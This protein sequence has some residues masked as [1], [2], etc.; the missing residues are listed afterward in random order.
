MLIAGIAV[1]VVVLGTGAWAVFFR[2]S[3]SAAAGVTYRATA[4]T[5]GTL[6]QTVSASG[7]VDATDTE[8]LAFPAS[9][10][11][12]GVWVAAGQKVTKGQR[13]AAIDSAQ[14]SSALAAARATLATAKAKL[15]S[16][17]GAS[18]TQVSA[19]NA[20]ITVAQNQVT[21]AT[22]DLDGATLTAPFAGTV[23]TVGYTVGQQV[24]SGSSSGTGSSSPSE[25]GS[26]T[27]SQGGGGT[28]S[29]SASSAAS[30]TSASASIHLVSTGSYEI[31]A[32]V[33]ATDVGKIAR[34]N[35]VT[36]TVGNSTQAVFGTVSSV[37]IVAT[38]TSG[39]ASFPVVV[40]VTGSPTGIYPGATASLQIVY[41]QLA[42]VLLVP[43]LAINRSGGATTVLVQNGSEQERRTVRT[44]LTSGAE[45]QITS[46][47]S[48]GQQVL[49]AIPTG[50]GTGTGTGTRTGRTG[51]GGTGGFP[52]GGTGGFPGGGT[53]G[54]PRG[55]TGTGGGNGG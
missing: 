25:T 4:V 41:K 55:G 8:D 34:N 23:T 54:F 27:G 49:V 14:L 9:G 47:L 22:A 36:I 45:T 42:D 1:L 38:T 31:D 39:V 11:V 46:G 24:G 19:D 21:A 16:D 6:R 50:L 51:T 48:A 32:T 18:S 13:L 3:S 53:G 5:S 17:S 40:A 20:S 10:Q 44:G 28:G 12:T 29:T 43:T 30:S 7:T 26:D 35:Q 52:G 37:G 2:T 33:D 15:A